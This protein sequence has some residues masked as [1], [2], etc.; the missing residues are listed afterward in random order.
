MRSQFLQQNGPGGATTAEQSGKLHPH[1]DGE[2]PRARPLL[3]PCPAAGAQPSP[4]HP[5]C[6]FWPEPPLRRV[7]APTSSGCSP[8]SHSL[9][10]S[11]RRTCQGALLPASCLSRRRRSAESSAAPSVRREGSRGLQEPP[12][13]WAAGGANGN[14]C[15]GGAEK[16]H[17]HSPARA[18]VSRR[19]GSKRGAGARLGREESSSCLQGTSAPGQ[20]HRSVGS[21]AATNCRR[22]RVA[23][24]VLFARLAGAGARLS[25][26]RAGVRELIPG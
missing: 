12:S 25:Y 21:S 15:L 13:G 14:P 18:A 19:Q 6:R 26:S 3:P 5:P 23:R 20:P 4:A 22:S 9:A 24:P 16:H 10:S 11:S 1:Q 2:P 17:G 7:S 8:G